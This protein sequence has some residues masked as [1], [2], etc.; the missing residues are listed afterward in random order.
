MFVES[1]VGTRVTCR[2]HSFGDTRHCPPE[3]H[4]SRRCV[5]FG[6]DGDAL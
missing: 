4:G 3:E 5:A 1:K 6:V 2:E